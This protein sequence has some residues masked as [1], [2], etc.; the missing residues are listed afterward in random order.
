MAIGST[1]THSG[2]L[3]GA[4]I[5]STKGPP[6]MALTETDELVKTDGVSYACTPPGS[7]SC[8][9]VLATAAAPPAMPMPAPNESVTV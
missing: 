9:L 1:S 3:S 2:G 6:D 7:A 5:H 4:N 8:S